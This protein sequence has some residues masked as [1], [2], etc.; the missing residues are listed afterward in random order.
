[1]EPRRERIFNVP[2]VVLATVVVLVGIHA[3]RGFLSPEQDLDLLAQFSF[4]P[5]RFTYAF[6]PQRVSDAYDSFAAT[7]E[8][9]A[10]IARFFLGDGKPLWWTP[11]TYAFLHGNWTHVGFNCLWFV[12]FGAAVARRFRAARF[13]IFALLAAFAGAL[14]HFLT[15][16]DDLQ[17]V[18]GASAV[19]SAT[20]AAASTIL[21]FSP[22]RRLARASALPAGATRST[23]TGSRRCRSSRSS[24]IGAPSPFSSSGSLRISCS[25]LPRVC[26][27]SALRR[28]LG[29]RMS[30][31]SCSDSSAFAYSI[32]RLP[33]W[34]P[35]NERD[36]ILAGRSSQPRR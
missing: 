26:R 33:I 4:V 28:S 31:A 36:H 11:I 34:L 15:H 2:L 24:R 8:T 32:R 14:A 29:R 19:V 6:D 13:L 12:A 7:D 17:P 30:A 1:M 9:R 20:M 23:R 3:L 16:T 18:I 25:A 21:S 5:G 35:I 27:A 22:A 10:E